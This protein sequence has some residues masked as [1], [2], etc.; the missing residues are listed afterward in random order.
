MVDAR[1]HLV[2][3]DIQRF[4]NCLQVFLMLIL[5]LKPQETAAISVLPQTDQI[6]VDFLDRLA[7]WQRIWGIPIRA[8]NESVP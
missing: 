8:F 1:Y 6:M 2:K 3:R 7:L 4:T 5:P